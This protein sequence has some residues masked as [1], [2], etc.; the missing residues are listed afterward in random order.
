MSALTELSISDYLDVR[1]LADDMVRLRLRCGVILLRGVKCGTKVVFKCPTCE[2]DAGYVPF[3]ADFREGVDPPTRN[4]YTIQLTNR[5]PRMPA[6]PIE[7]DIDEVELLL[8]SGEELSPIMS[9][10]GGCTMAQIVDAAMIHLQ[11]LLRESDQLKVRAPTDYQSTDTPTAAHRLKI[12]VMLAAS[13]FGGEKYITTLIQ[14]HMD[15]L[16]DCCQ[17]DRTFRARLLAKHGFGG[18]DAGFKH[19]YEVMM[20]FHRA[21]LQFK[22][23]PKAREAQAQQ[24]AT[25]LLHERIFNH[26]IL[27]GRIDDATHRARALGLW[28]SNEYNARRQY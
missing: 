5:P 7:L 15:Y 13:S 11:L 6:P 19:M 28:L 26:P 23:D 14:L 27:G 18:E 24:V 12:M 17:I 20:R 25:Q 1:G 21:F 16:K 9:I 10:G 22:M 2:V 4:V 8:D 3:P